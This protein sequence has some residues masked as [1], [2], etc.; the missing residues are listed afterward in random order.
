VSSAIWTDLTT[1]VT[2][3]C[4]IVYLSLFN[5]FHTELREDRF[6]KSQLRLFTPHKTGGVFNLGAEILRSNATRATVKQDVGESPWE[7]ICYCESGTLAV[8]L[9]FLGHNW[10]KNEIWYLNSIQK[11]QHSF[12]KDNIKW[13][14]PGNA[15]HIQ[16]WGLLEYIASKTL[17]NIFN[18]FPFMPISAVGDKIELYVPTMFMVKKVTC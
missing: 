15:I 12:Q 17:A 1:V 18:P 7:L 6:F 10:L 5:K 14:F 2:G 4:F 9:L 8:I 13:I 3:R 16:I 11:D